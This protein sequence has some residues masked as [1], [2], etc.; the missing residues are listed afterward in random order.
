MLSHPC[1]SGIPKER[2]TKSEVATSALPSQW[3]EEQGGGGE[4]A[5]WG[6]RIQLRKIAEKLRKNCGKLRKI[7]ENG[8]KIAM[9]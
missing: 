7:A 5:V 1:I 4:I 2:G 8:G 3:P 9:S 6:G